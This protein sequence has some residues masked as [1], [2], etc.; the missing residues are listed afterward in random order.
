MRFS[1]ITLKAIA[2]AGTLFLL[3]VALELP[4]LDS[5]QRARPV[6]RAIVAIVY[7]MFFVV[8]PIGLATYFNRAWRRVSS[9]PNRTAYVIWLSLESIAGAGVLGMLVY[10]TVEFAVSRFR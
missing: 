10:A 7:T 3:C 8:T 6:V 1:R 2:F 5:H 4:S 9:V